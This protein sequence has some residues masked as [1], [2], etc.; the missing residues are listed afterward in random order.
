MA[1]LVKEP[2]AGSPAPAAPR[3]RR[4]R[5]TR[6]RALPWAM[7]TPTLIVF[8]VALGYPLAQL[9]YLSL[10][11]YGP[12][13]LFTGESG[14]AGLGNFTRVLG[15]GDF[16]DVVARTIV[17]TTVCVVAMMVLGFLM[18]HVLMGVSPWVRAV[19]TSSLALV[20]AMPMVA[21][22]LVWRWM[23]QP[24]YG[25]ANWILTRMRVFGD[26]TARDWFNHPRQGL[27]LIALL[28]VW[29]GLPFVALTMF[30][31][32]G[33]IPRSFYEAA[34]LDGAGTLDI[35]RH[36][37]IPIMRPILA[38]LAV[39]EVIW[40]VNSFTP[41][42]VLTQGGPSGKTTTLG[43]YAYITAFS[44]N[45]YGVGAAIAVLTVLLLAVFAAL[46]VRRLSAQGDM[47]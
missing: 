28:T 9:L 37:T 38:I 6:P 19:T 47:P 32:R 2:R 43:V 13:S 39:L 31:A 18:A 42:W 12:R 10:R 8:V 7:L 23:Y 20:W 36:V 41:I 3:R 14:F 34:R 25:V 16:W 35:F 44:A 15:D 33:Q 22:T 27:A 21:A 11:D 40:S 5:P 1:T 26:L 24:Q 45:Q 46:Y 29:K 4:R 17:F 30:A